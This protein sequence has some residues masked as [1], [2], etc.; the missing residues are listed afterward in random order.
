[1]NGAV[2][3]FLLTAVVATGQPRGVGVDD[4]ADVQRI[5]E[6]NAAEAMLLLL[7]AVDQLQQEW[8]ERRAGDVRRVVGLLAAADVDQACLREAVLRRMEGREL[9]PNGEISDDGLFGGW[10]LPCPDDDER[11]LFRLFRDA[12]GL[13]G[14]LDEDCR[15]Y[16][17]ISRMYSVLA[18]LIGWNVEEHYRNASYEADDGSVL[19]HLE[20]EQF[21]NDLDYTVYV[22]GAGS[23]CARWNE[24]LAAALARRLSIA[25]RADPAMAYFTFDGLHTIWISARG[26]LFLEHVDPDVRDAVRTTV[27]FAIRELLEGNG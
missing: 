18:D 8:D 3:M 22:A 1:M 23:L 6:D 12:T 15:P 25:V 19:A 4:L 14:L 7:H 5:R 20:A 17:G 24:D 10:D 13:P 2:A 11:I 26:S 27:R 9:G 16:A 21:A